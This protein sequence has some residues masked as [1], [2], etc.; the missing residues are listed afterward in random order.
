MNVYQCRVVFSDNTEMLRAILAM[1]EDAA[2]QQIRQTMTEEE[3]NKIDRIE[4][5]KQKPLMG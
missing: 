5:I 1:T 3:L 4:I 2:E